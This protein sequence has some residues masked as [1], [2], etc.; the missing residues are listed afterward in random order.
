[1]IRL[2][3]EKIKN[4]D[5]KNVIILTGAGMGVD[6]GLPDYRSKE[7]FWKEFP[8]AKEMGISFEDSAMPSWFRIDPQEA[9]MF[10]GYRTNLY[11]KAIPHKGFYLLK[12]FVSDKNHF[13]I[14]SNI[15]NMFQKAEFDS[16]KIYEMHGNLFTLQCTKVNGL[17]YELGCFN[18]YKNEKYTGDVPICDCGCALRPNIQMF[19]DHQ[20]NSSF[21]DL[22]EKKLK[23]FI[24]NIENE[25]LI[26]EIG[27][28]TALP[29]IR[30]YSE[31]LKRTIGG[32]FFVRINL[33]EC[34]G[35]A[36]LSLQE[37]AL[38]GLQKIFN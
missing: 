2:L 34:Q 35:N 38:N 4:K 5:F 27:A 13:I 17:F 15:D 22:Q 3:K 16:N 37:S 18:S 19:G 21:Y 29:F 30:N 28:G 7:G 31:T 24:K 26:I 14:T 36:N 6:S 12:D 32:S 33:F 8:M 20:W 23:E 1:M 9:W 25:T 11:K 10:Y